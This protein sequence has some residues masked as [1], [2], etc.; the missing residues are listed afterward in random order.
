MMKKFLSVG[1]IVLDLNTA[2]N[3]LINLDIFKGL[4][5][6]LNFSSSLG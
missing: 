4:D 3:I 5:K 6:L 1:N 2:F